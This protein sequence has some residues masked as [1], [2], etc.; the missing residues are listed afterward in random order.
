MDIIDLT[1]KL[2]S[3]PS[4][5]DGQTDEK[6]IGKFIYDYLKKFS[7]LKVSKQPVTNGRFN[8][9]AKDKY[10]IKLLLIGHIDTVQPRQGWKTDP[11]KPVIKKGKIYGL[12]A[13]DMK[14]GLAAILSTLQKLEKTRG[15]M[16][17]FYIDEEYD[18]LGSKKFISEFKGKIEPKLII[19]ADG[20]DLKIGTGCR[21]LIE[22]KFAV[23]GRSGHAARPKSGKNAIDWSFTAINNLKNYL[24][25]FST[26]ELGKTTIN[27]AFF[28]G[29]LNL[30][31]DKNNQ[32]IL[33]QEGNNVADVAKFTVDI[34]PASLDL[35]AT[36]VIK[37]I[38]SFLNINGLKLI[39]KKIKH[40]LSP[41]L[42]KKSEIK[43]IAKIIKKQTPIKHSFPNDT[44]FIDVQMFW[45]TFNKV[46]CLT[47]G[48]GEGK[49]AHKPNEFVK[50]KNLLKTGQVFQKVINELLC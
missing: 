27:T 4:Y 26:K 8:I 41:W 29:G 6:E 7:W 18:F 15:L 16:L 38:E 33:G 21:G 50:I 25:K 13:T 5:V 2:V 45:E 39:N 3:I 23:E 31:Q 10:P 37:K 22:I 28:Q 9:I 43:K 32:L 19:S 47:F 48:A 11:L 1:K 36:K 17:L 24:E 40:D 34:R 14:S 42:T 35:N 30:G 49:L 46:P 20:S 12:G 44:G